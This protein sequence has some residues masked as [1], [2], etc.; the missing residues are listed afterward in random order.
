MPADPLSDVLA[1]LGAQGVRGTRLEAS[2]D[3]ALS[4]QG[5]KRLQFVA[6]LRGRCWLLLPDQPPE[7]LAKGDVFLLNDTAFAVASDP[8]MDRTDGMSLFE[9]PGQ[10]VVR[11]GQ[12]ADTVMVGGGSTFAGDRA[13]FVLDA[14]PAFLRVDRDSPRA[15]A[16]ARI[17]LALA[18]E[19]GGAFPG[20]A[21]VTQRLAEILIVE[22]IRAYA[23][24]GST[25]RAGWI[26]ALTD[27]K[28][29]A[30]LQLMH[31]D[32]ARPWTA[33]ALAAEVGMSRSAFTQRFS[34]RV[35]RPPLDYL[36][37]WRMTLARSRLATGTA[38]I[39]Q[40]AVEVGYGSQS[41]FAQAFKRT[42][43]VTPRSVV[44]GIP[45]LRGDRPAS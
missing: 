19:V 8:A 44:A 12:R 32:I 22:A 30:A 35:G 3:W 26:A 2:G 25:H 42:F 37:G 20:S 38:S 43:G 17:L 16:V 36:I 23:D 7:A 14:L 34:A 21:L 41:A 39:A 27:A 15:G 24:A 5:Q 31:G 33:A 10:D 6:V 9:G 18:T 11:V 4:F 28:I 1:A 40:V 13:G 29:G 45:E